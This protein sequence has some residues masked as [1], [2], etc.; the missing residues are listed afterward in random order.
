MTGVSAV[1]DALAARLATIT[2]LNVYSTFPAVPQPP[3]VIVQ[4]TTGDYDLS[5]A[6][7]GETMNFDLVLLAIQIASPFD[8][9]QDAIDPYLD[10]SGSTSLRSTINADVSLAGTVH[11]CRVKGWQNYGTINVG[12][13]EYLGA[14][15][16]VEVWP[17]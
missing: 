8:V 6:N 1:R 17:L 9:A 3:C 7:G 15:L 16:A 11:T 10:R 4:P 12:G 14:K 2:G 5:L 13:S